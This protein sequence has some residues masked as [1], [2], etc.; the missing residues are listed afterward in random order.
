ISALSVR[1]GPLP[2]VRQDERIL[3][4]NGKRAS[5][6]TWYR[7]YWI[8]SM[9]CGLAPGTEV[10]ASPCPYRHPGRSCRPGHRRDKVD[11][12]D[13][14]H[15]RVGG[16]GRL[17]VVCR[18]GT[19]LKRVDLEL[20]SLHTARSVVVLSPPGD[21]PDIDVIKVLLLLHNRP[22]PQRRPHVVAA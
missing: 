7:Q 2:A 19:P 6:E 16:T 15:A 11:M 21:E 12:Q 1:T 9:K 4:M 3:R 5:M 10:P 14:L 20:V 8:I 22:W 18:S 13:Q 17:R